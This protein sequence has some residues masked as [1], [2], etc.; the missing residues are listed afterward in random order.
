M[1]HDAYEAIFWVSASVISFF[2]PLSVLRN[3]HTHDKLRRK[4]E[5]ILTPGHPS[6]I[7]GTGQIA[8]V[9]GLFDLVPVNW[10]SHNFLRMSA[11]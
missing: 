11:Y 3:V 7:G 8:T 2:L 6:N 10:R 5:V 1:S 4:I 9:K